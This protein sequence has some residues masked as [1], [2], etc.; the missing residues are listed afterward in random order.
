[1][2]LS[3]AL[4]CVLSMQLR[5]TSTDRIVAVVA[6]VIEGGPALVRDKA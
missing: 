1:V 5:A 4:R 6:A 2:C 3:D